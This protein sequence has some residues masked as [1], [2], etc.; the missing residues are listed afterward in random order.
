MGPWEGPV[1]SLQLGS[2]W[3][4]PLARLAV[5]VV[6]KKIRSPF[7]EKSEGKKKKLA[8]QNEAI[9]LASFSSVNLLYSWKL[10]FRIPVPCA[11]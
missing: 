5:Q 7:W 2:R 9:A 3:P 1:M 4:V 11:L 10:C 8:S 6:G